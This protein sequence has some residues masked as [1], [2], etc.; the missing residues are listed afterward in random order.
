M[1]NNKKL[2]HSEKRKRK[3][4]STSCQVLDF[5]MYKSDN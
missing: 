4:V 1:S 2:R 3:E 5:I